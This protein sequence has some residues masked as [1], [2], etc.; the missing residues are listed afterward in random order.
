[1]SSLSSFSHLFLLYF[2]TFVLYIIFGFLATFGSKIFVLSSRDW[3]L[4]LFWSLSTIVLPKIQGRDSIPSQLISLL[5]KF[6]QSLSKAIFN[7]PRKGKVAASSRARRSGETKLHS[8]ISWVSEISQI[9]SPRLTLKGWWNNYRTA[10]QSLT[11]KCK[12]IWAWWIS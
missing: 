2:F 6:E 8:R 7:V 3:T 4:R 11:G 9:S 12:R 1:M 10:M 5:I